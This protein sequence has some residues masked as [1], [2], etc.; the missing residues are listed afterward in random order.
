M[1]LAITDII[2]GRGEGPVESQTSS[3]SVVLPP[4]SHGSVA[5]L[6]SVQRGETASTPHKRP[7]E[8]ARR[9]SISPSLSFPAT[10]V[11]VHPKGGFEVMKPPT[12]PGQSSALTHSLQ[13]S[14]SLTASPT[15]D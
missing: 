2:E 4:P 1:E 6:Q 13:L 12:Q 7:S 15:Y 10:V 5:P 11:S 9:P 8:E 14:H 3:A